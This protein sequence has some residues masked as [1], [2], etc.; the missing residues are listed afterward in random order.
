MSCRLILLVI[1]RSVRRVCSKP[2]RHRSVRFDTDLSN[3][4]RCVGSCESVV[5]MYLDRCFPLETADVRAR[6][7]AKLVCYWLSRDDLLY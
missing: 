2:I 7:F 4:C 3:F 5:K 1:V 6:R